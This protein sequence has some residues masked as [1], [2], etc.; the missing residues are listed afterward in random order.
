MLGDFSEGIEDLDEALKLE[1]E[2]AWALRHRGAAKRRLGDV[3]E[4]IADLD[5]ALQFDP[6]NSFA[7]ACRGEVK[8]MFGYFVAAIED[9]NLALK[10]EPN[11]TFALVVR[12]EVKRQQKDLKGAIADLD[13]LVD[14]EPTKCFPFCRRGEVK[15]QQGDIAGAISDFQS[16]LRLDPNDPCARRGRREAL[17]ALW[18][19]GKQTVLARLQ[20]G[21]ALKWA[22]IG[23]GPVGLTLAL[24][25][26]EAMWQKGMDPT[27]VGIEVYESRWIKELPDSPEAPK[28]QRNLDSKALRL[29]E[30]NSESFQRQKSI[31]ACISIIPTQ[32]WDTRR[33]Q[34]QIF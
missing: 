33:R 14:L 13:L 1:P 25:L 17:H 16:A 2:D 34:K 22:I 9:L 27:A 29:S 24:S 21:Q 20:A 3:D 23:A 26:A 8:R 6:T 15:Q 12:S 30:E 19:L 11:N 4:A 28:W 31:Q 7:L 5:L 18:V 32:L 10:L